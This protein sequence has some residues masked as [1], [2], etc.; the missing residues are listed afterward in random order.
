M[1]LLSM[2]RKRCMK[3]AIETRKMAIDC[4]AAMEAA[5][6]VEAAEKSSAET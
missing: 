6:T 2:S 3:V 5:M 4:V 1:K